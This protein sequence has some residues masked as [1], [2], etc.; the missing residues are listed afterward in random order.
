MI[1]HSGGLGVQFWHPFFISTLPASSIRDGLRLGGE[2]WAFVGVGNWQA[3]HAVGLA[4]YVHL[5]KLYLPLKNHFFAHD[6]INNARA[7]AGQLVNMDVAASLLY[8]TSPPDD[9][10]SQTDPV[11]TPLSF[12]NIIGYWVEV[13]RSITC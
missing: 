2:W 13:F 4:G 5:F 12:L 9:F 8:V 11:P 6:V 3:T 7:R 1:G 10:V